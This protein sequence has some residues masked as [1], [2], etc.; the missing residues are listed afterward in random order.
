MGLPKGTSY[1]MVT[2]GRWVT[3][4]C[5][6]RWWAFGP[7]NSGDA[8]G[9]KAPGFQLAVLSSQSIPES[10]M[11][12]TRRQTSYIDCALP[13]AEKALIAHIRREAAKRGGTGIV[14]GI[15]D[16]GAEIGIPR[17][18]QALVT[19]DFS[20]EN[21]HFR[22]AWHP[23]EAV[24][25]RCL[26]RGLS[27]IAAMGGEPLAAF[28]S[29]ALPKNLSQSW[30]DG[31]VRGLLG[32]AA[33]FD[34]SL[35]GGDTAQSPGGILADIVV[36][37]SAPKGKAVR[38]SGAHVGD[39]IYVTGEL[40]ASS[41]TLGLLRKGKRLR[42]AEYEAH[43]YPE[44]R[45]VV[46]RFLRERSLASAMIDLSDGLSTDLGHICDES[47]VGAEVEAQAIPLATIGRPGREVALHFALHG[48]EDYELLFTAGRRLPE[49]IAGVR[50]TEIG[51]VTRRKVILRGKHGVGS[52]LRPQGWEHFRESRR[53]RF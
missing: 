44:P 28:L 27:D 40:G 22:Q 8:A 33:R 53:K 49:R 35:A 32:L 25:H 47:E 3:V 51:W 13:L 26:A 41:A 18:H 31:F 34:V 9:A 19:T 24:G 17:G 15:G 38:R 21:V 16:D 29:L 20:L 37:G 14:L 10:R 1:S 52:E 43:F 46:G 2:L 50:V 5:V 7:A 39:R 42:P 23:A 6:A 4:L 36:L 48:G 45:I 12:R 11:S 30:V